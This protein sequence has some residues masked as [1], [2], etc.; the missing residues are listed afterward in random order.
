[1]L[2]THG[3]E[4]LETVMY[5]LGISVSHDSSVC[6]LKDGDVRFALS[7]ERLVKVKRGLVSARQYPRAMAELIEYCLHAEG[8]D[9]ER[10]DYFVI[11]ST[12]NAN[13]TEERSTFRDLGMFPDRKI[14]TLPHPSHHLAHASAA[15]YSSG[16]DDAVALVVDAYGSVVGEGRESESAFLFKVGECPEPLFSNRRN[17]QRVA[18]LLNDGKFVVPKQLHGIGEIYR[19]VTLILGFHQRGSYYDDP[20]KTMGLAP[21]GNCQFD[22]P[23]LIRH[24]EDGL[25]YSNAYSF[26]L[27]HHLISEVDGISYLNVRAEGAPYSQFLK[28]IA[29]QLQWEFEEACLHLAR[30]ALQNAPA[31][32]LVLGGGGFLNS[33]TNHRLIDELP[34]DDIFIFP[35]ATDDGN[36]V[37]A[38]LYAY[39]NCLKHAVEPAKAPRSF[40]FGRTYTN[41][42]IAEALDASQLDYEKLVDDRDVSIMAAEKLANGGSIGWFQGGA[43]FGP[44][45]LGNR[46]ILANPLLMDTKDTLNNKVKFREGFRPFG[47]AVIEEQVERYFELAH[48]VS[49]LMLLVCQVRESAK[50]LIP[51]I[52]HVDG[53]CR[54]QTV[55]KLD[56][57]LFYQLLKDFGNL[58]DNPILLNTSFNLRGMP[59]VETP[60]DALNC[61]AA[62]ELSALFIGQYAVAAPCYETFVPV[63]HDLDFS[64]EGVLLRS[65]QDPQC[66]VF[67]VTPLHNS[68]TRGLSVSLS[69][70]QWEAL[71][72]AN[73]QA[74]IE[75]LAT[76]IG[77][78]RADLVTLYL[79]LF[80]LNL[81][82]W[83]HITPAYVNEQPK[84]HFNLSVA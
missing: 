82:Y 31:N 77:M 83:E 16:F 72:L 2:S 22:A 58:T 71:H 65:S 7:L 44:R 32:K 5:I 66:E 67:T 55:S 57:P 15:F 79:E 29:A 43:E 13:E 12:E 30:L 53:T 33:V 47:G 1:M 62:T 11:N 46:S 21:Y 70:K 34:I 75:T 78:P 69:A 35:A 48:P 28:D 81:I 17:D 49:P 52:T 54:V 24:T 9:F 40:F 60:T 36:S 64:T 4:K 14:I 23:Q 3:S 68:R 19:I 10:V 84:A 39:H 61:F 56:N 37:G 26:L 27:A 6:L 59:I 74:S 51:S 20:G 80:R 38:A 45:A 73:G 42:T 50:P 76:R 25:D 63:R 8:I 41:D 18:G